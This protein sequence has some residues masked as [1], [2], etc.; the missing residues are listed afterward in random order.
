MIELEV[1]PVECIGVRTQIAFRIARQEIPSGFVRHYAEAGSQCWN[2]KSLTVPTA[3][4]ACDCY[5]EIIKP[6]H[7]QIKLYVRGSMPIQDGNI[8]RCRP[9]DFDKIR[10]A[11]VELNMNLAHWTDSASLE[12]EFFSRSHA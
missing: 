6:A 5:P 4:I 1:Y 7:D 9:E 3:Q 10:R 8:L 2:W 12:E 11:L